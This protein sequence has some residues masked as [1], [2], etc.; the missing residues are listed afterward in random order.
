[1]LKLKKEFDK[2]PVYSDEELD[3]MTSESLGNYLDLLEAKQ[4]FTKTHKM[5]YF[6][7]DDWCKKFTKK[8]EDESVCS[9]IASNRSGKSYTGTWLLTCHLTG[10]YPEDY[11]GFRYTTEIAAWIM[12]P[13]AENYVQAGGLQEYMLGKP[14]EVGTGWIPEECIIKVETGMGTKGFIKKVYVQHISGKVST[15]EYKSY[16]Q[17]SNML[18]GANIDLAVI[19]EEPKDEKIFPEVV[20]RLAQAPSG[21]GRIILFFTPTN[22]KTPLV[23]ACFEGQYKEGCVRISVWDCSFITEEKI[24]EMKRTIPEREWDLRLKG[25]PTLGKGAVFPQAEHQIKFIGSDVVIEPHWKVAAAIDFGYLPDPCAILF[26]AL[27]QDRGIYYVFKEFY[28]TEKTVAE[29]AG[30]IKRFAPTIPVIYPADG[31]KKQQAN[32]GKT[33]QEMF[34]EEGINMPSS[35]RVDYGKKGERE[36]GH[37]A[38]RTLFRQGQLY[39]SNAC[40]NWFREFRVYQYDEK[41]DTNKC[42]DH[43]MDALR[44]LI[45]K[46]DTVGISW[47][48]AQSITRPT[49]RRSTMNKGFTPKF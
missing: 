2:L 33:L 22:G 48:D 40:E 25:L 6:T 3:S 46:I 28:E 38:L 19:D 23:E 49:Y 26:G 39:L 45:Q 44:Y 10:I 43:A 14:N 20:T 37:V 21:L 8:M 36:T 16:S 1:M 17:G 24:E 32:Q 15:L 7:P 4:E 35:N 9:L 11:Q 31:N 42:D 29:I 30:W 47:K 27:D 13:T 5:L 12:S 41:G 34:V 18:Q